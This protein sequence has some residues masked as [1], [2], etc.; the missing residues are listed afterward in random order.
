MANFIPHDVVHL[1]DEVARSLVAKHRR[2]DLSMP[3][4]SML[5]ST[6]EVSR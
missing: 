2:Q 3:S 1:A 4:S 6:C 5:S